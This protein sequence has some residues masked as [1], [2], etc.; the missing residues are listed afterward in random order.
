MET[1]LD[2]IFEEQFAICEKKNIKS[3]DFITLC[4]S[5]KGEENTVYVLE[6]RIRINEGRTYSANGIVAVCEDGILIEHADGAV[7]DGLFVK[8]SIKIVNSKHVFIKN[9]HIQ[10]SV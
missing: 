1:A 8:G 9:C 3:D 6:G 4:E 10:S 2:S 7:I 5:G